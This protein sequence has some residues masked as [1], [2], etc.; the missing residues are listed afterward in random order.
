MLTHTTGAMTTSDMPQRINRDWTRGRSSSST[1]ATTVAPTVEKG[2]KSTTEAQMPRDAITAHP[3]RS[4]RVTKGIARGINAAIIPV[5]DANAATKEPIKQITKA[6]SHGL[7]TSD[8][9]E[10]HTSEL[11]SRFDLVC[12]LLLEKKK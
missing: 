1:V 9:S 5:V 4:P 7:P 10:E 3:A 2:D 8:R 11:Q 6:A 12:R